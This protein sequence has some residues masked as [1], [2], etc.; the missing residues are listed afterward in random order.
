V[1]NKRLSVRHFNR[2]LPEIL[3][4]NLRIFSCSHLAKYPSQY[5]SC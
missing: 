1:E 3:Q 5:Y 4:Y 2:L